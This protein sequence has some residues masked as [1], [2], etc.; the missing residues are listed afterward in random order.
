M[1][2]PLPS[3]PR[4]PGDEG[5]E[6]FEG[7]YLVCGSDG[8]CRDQASDILSIAGYGLYFGPGHSQNVSEPLYAP[9]QTAQRAEV[10]T[11]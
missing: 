10:Q 3:P 6:N 2:P 7:D 9:V 1:P 11:V 8:A 4:A 5:V